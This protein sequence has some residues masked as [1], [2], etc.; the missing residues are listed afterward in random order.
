M[1]SP[2]AGLGP[3]PTLP[4]HL[5]NDLVSAVG[6]DGM[7]QRPT[8]NVLHGHFLQLLHPDPTQNPANL[9]M[10]FRKADLPQSSLGM[11]GEIFAVRPHC[12]L[13]AGF[14]D[15]LGLRASCPCPLKKRQG[16]R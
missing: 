11:G 4:L 16:A 13:Q 15:V 3:Q 9:A 12:G 6:I 1:R 10:P 7:R 8:T 5:L 14:I 2:F